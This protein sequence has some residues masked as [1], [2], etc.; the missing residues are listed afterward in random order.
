MV[1][2]QDIYQV[3]MPEITIKQNQHSNM[4]MN[5]SEQIKQVFFEHLQGNSLLL[6]ISSNTFN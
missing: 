4:E 6:K 2:C 1:T 5:I 3:I